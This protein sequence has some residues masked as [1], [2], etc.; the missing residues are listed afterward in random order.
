VWTSVWISFPHPTLVGIGVCGLCR[1]LTPPKHDEVLGRGQG[2]AQ[3]AVGGGTG[4][5]VDEKRWRTRRTDSESETD[6]VGGQRQRET[7]E[8]EERGG[9]SGC[10]RAA[11]AGRSVGGA[12]GLRGFGGREEAVR[13]GGERRAAR[14]A[15][16]PGDWLSRNAVWIVSGRWAWLPIGIGRSWRGSR[17]S[18]R[19]ARRTSWRV[20]ASAE[21]L[22]IGG[23][24][25]SWTTACCRAR[26]WCTGS[27]R[28]TCRRA[29]GLPGPG[30][31]RSSRRVSVSPVVT[32][33][34]RSVVAWVAVIGAVS[35]Q[36]VMAR[37]G[38]GALAHV[39]R[40]D[41]VTAMRPRR[42]RAAAAAEALRWRMWRSSASGS[43]SRHV[44]SGAWNGRAPRSEALMPPWG[45]DS[46]HV[47][48]ADGLAWGSR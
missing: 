9:R 34:D 48:P 47:G 46:I 15:S 1:A 13:G 11:R 33:R 19:S 44:V 14:A 17:S 6:G 4:T 30:S 32:D 22:A 5:G 7:R 12:D 41:G 24:G 35:A 43:A 26:A 38:V 18:G 36:D 42:M 25:R 21:P 28:S 40:C 10:G 31:R 37:F 16:Q 20:L 3:E 45:L 23:F 39:A 27:R 8:A 29:K 2:P